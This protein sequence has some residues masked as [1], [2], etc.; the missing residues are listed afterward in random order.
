MSEKENE[1]IGD[2]ILEKRPSISKSSLKT[3]ESILRNLYNKVFKNIDEKTYNLS[4][5][6]DSKTIIDFLK[7]VPANKRKTILS[8]LVVITDNKDYREMMLEDI[9]EYNKE[10]AKQKKTETQKENWVDTEDITKLYKNLR[11]NANL[12]YKKNDLS[13]SDYQDI[14]NY[15]IL[16]L[17][18]GLYIP[19]RRS[20]DYVNFKIKNIDKEKDNYINKNIF[21][22]NSYKTA[23]TYGQQ[24]VEIPI[25]LKKILNKWIKINPT[26]Y[27]L[28]DISFNPLS[29]VKL[30]QRLNKLFG[31]KVGVN[32]M[33]KTF[34]S[35]KYS[36][37]IDKKNELNEDM[38][39]MGSSKNQENIY[40][41]K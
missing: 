7:K 20:K 24:Q 28:F 12:L 36:D 27:L 35:D 37:L 5:F 32:Q 23:K 13:P 6:D 25:E 18:G 22:F 21:I 39:K 8:A 3:Y 40:I 4:R 33:R 16:S 31:K 19:P 2:Y 1:I 17:F 15:I 41:K 11:H 26:D 38:A 29:N 30:N 10:E 9:K 34:L 14:Q